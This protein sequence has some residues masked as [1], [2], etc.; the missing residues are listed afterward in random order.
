MQY[1]SKNHIISI[2]SPSFP[3]ASAGFMLVLLFDPE[4]WGGKLMQNFELSSNCT[5][6]QSRIPY[7]VRNHRR[8]NL[9]SKAILNLLHEEIRHIN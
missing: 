1:S 3:P 5:A 7:V 2:I 9:K 6:L 8:E 4:N